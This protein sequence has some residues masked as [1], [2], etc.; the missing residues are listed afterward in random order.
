[1]SPIQEEVIQ[2]AKRIKTYMRNTSRIFYRAKQK[3]KV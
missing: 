1:M 3:N 2:A